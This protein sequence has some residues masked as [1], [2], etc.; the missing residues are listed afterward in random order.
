ML[1]KMPVVENH[2]FWTLLEKKNTA[3]Y[4]NE[5]QKELEIMMKADAE[6]QYIT[7]TVYALWLCRLDKLLEKR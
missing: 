5:E 7:R 3:T 2:R 1:Y 6:I 4:S